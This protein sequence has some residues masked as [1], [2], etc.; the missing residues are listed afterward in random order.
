MGDGGNA[1]GGALNV[2]ISKTSKTHFDL[3]TVY[4]GPEYSDDQILSELKKNNL[5]FHIL[6]PKNKAQ[7]VSEQI[8]KGEIVGRT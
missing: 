6:N 2:A 3:P 4:L 1:L 7:I 8:A 5:N